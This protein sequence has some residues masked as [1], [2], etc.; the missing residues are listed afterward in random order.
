MNRII[1][2]AFGTTRP[3]EIYNSLL[4]FDRLVTKPIVHIV[5]WAGL[6]L[7]FLAACGVVGWAVGQAWQDPNPMA[8]VLA[9][10]MTV[11]GWLLLLIGVLIWRSA[12]EFYMAVLSIAEDLRTLRQYQEK[13][14]TPS[15][16]VPVA[17]PQPQVQPAAETFAPKID[18]LKFEPPS[19]D[20]EPAPAP[21][22]GN[23]LEDPFFR[24]RFRP[25]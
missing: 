19:A 1:R 16:A 13:L 25:D 10:A 17:A 9:F 8:W 23:I 6:C 24:P 14:E 22:T 3:G 21:E 18:P 4:T 15:A 20:S 2:Q 11:V 5:Y 7:F 12:C